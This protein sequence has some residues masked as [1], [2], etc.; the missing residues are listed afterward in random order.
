MNLSFNQQLK[1]T[2]QEK[3]NYLCIGL[4]IDPEKFSK[5]KIRTLDA[6]ETFGKEIIDGTIN[7]CPAYKP[8]FAFYERFGSQGYAV[9]ERLVDYIDGRAIVIAD[10]KRGDIGN[11]SRQYARSILDTMGCDAITISPYMGRD[12]IEPFI[13]NPEKGVFV[14]V[15]TS[16]IGA[17]EIQEHG[18]KV[19][20]LY[21]KIIQKAD[22][23]NYADNIGLVVG[24]TQTDIM[25]DIRK[26]SIEIPW[27]IPGV[28]SQGGDLEKALN[29]SH[30]EGMA[31]I[32]ISRGIL[33]SGD[34]ST[35]A[36]IQA[37]RDYTNKIRG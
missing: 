18:G 31:I 28:G 35:T 26:L 5:G 15:V 4:D 9:L 29:I 32:N 19:D 17:R 33:Y 34:G 3:N 11:T 6:M 30:D 36:V 10:A 14:L 37:A 20:P 8:N 12:A 24:A 21:K 25:E 1:E 23:L 16:N 27:L 7:F 22:E 13:E 2:C